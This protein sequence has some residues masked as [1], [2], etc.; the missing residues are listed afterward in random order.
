MRATS[1]HLYVALT[2]GVTALAAAGLT[3][4]AASAAPSALDP[5]PSHG[6]KV[7]YPT[8]QAAL[9]SR[10]AHAIGRFVNGTGVL[11][12]GGG[13]SGVGVTTAAPKVYLVFWGSQWGTQGTDVKGDFTFTGDPEGMA[14]RLQE[15]FKGIGTNSEQWSGVMTQY[16]DTTLG[17]TSC[18]ASAAH[19]GY[20][21]GGALAGVWYDSSTEPPTATDNEIGTEALAASAHFSNTDA[22]A[23]VD[24]QYVVVSPTGAHPGGF[25]TSTANWCAWHDW[26]GDSTLNGGAVQTTYPFAFTNLPYVTD[27]GPS[28]GQNYVNS[29]SAGTLDGVTIVSGHEY[30]ETITDQF[31]AGG[32]TDRSGY[33]NADKCAWVGV[34]GTGG[35]QNVTFATG[36]FAMQGTYSNDSTS[37]RISHPIVT[38]STGTV[39]STVTVD[40]PGAQSTPR[41]TS[42]SLQIVGS[43]STSLSLTWSASGLPA[44]LS[45]DSSTGLISGT[46]GKRVKTYTVTVAATATD[47][48]SGSTTFSWTIT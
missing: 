23:N 34:G 28:C 18:P 13:V 39:T 29:G 40:N 27:L 45:I 21:T 1:R 14:P 38:S 9:H 16:C 37:C 43:D 15:M 32:W 47:G 19:V 25:N 5:A 35:A 2:L 36:R 3:A 7:V 17:A 4:T 22:A 48:A 6:H 26:S 33:E 30:A 24:A 31:P 8:I 11:A 41:R 44:G 12:Y 10:A 20:P 46:T 42:V